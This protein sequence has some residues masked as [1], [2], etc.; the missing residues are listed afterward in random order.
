LPCVPDRLAQGMNG[1]DQCDRHV[2]HR[3]R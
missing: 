1:V 3:S 2:S